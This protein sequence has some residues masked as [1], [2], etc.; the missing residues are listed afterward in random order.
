MFGP[1]AELAAAKANSKETDAGVDTISKKALR[2]DGGDLKRESLFEAGRGKGSWLNE[3]DMNFL[4]GGGPSEAADVPAASPEEESTVRRRLLLGIAAT[5]A[6]GAFAL[7]PTDALRLDKP[8][9]PL[10]MYLV[11]LVRIQALLKESS[12]IVENGRYEELSAVLRRIQGPPN[13]AEANLRDAAARLPDQRAR[14]RAESTAR[15]VIEYINSIDSNKYFDSM[16]TPGSR[17]GAIEKQATAFSLQST[18]AAEAKLKEFLAFMPREDLE[19]AQQ[20][21]SALPF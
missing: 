13:N 2:I 15:D 6:L 3:S 16:G 9:K 10:F 11:P 4:T 17:G 1:V 8:N 19:A 12:D 18:K 7:V 14:E 5:V 21:A 20:Q